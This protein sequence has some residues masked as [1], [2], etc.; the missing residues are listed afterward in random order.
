MARNSREQLV[1]FQAS[2][3]ALR[4]AEIDISALTRG[5]GPGIWGATGFAAD[6]NAGSATLRGL[7][8]PATSGDQI[9]RTAP[10][11]AWVPFGMY[12]GRTLFASGGV[13]G[14]SAQPS[15]LIEVITAPMPGASIKV[16][17]NNAR[18]RVTAQGVG[19]SNV[20]Q[21]RVQTIYR[22]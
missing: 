8:L 9:W 14:V 17:T 5:G 10:A 11:N 19:P 7:C 4:D 3:G 20:V 18:Y 21:Y 16:H 6:C 15:Y 2:E 22:P 1:A 12:S 13:A